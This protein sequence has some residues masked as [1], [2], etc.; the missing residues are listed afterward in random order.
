MKKVNELK[1][2]NI[3]IV[4]DMVIEGEKII[5]KMRIER[6]EKK[7]NERIDRR[8]EEKERENIVDLGK[9]I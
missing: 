3:G 6:R 5:D 2:K 1:N 4:E 8:K 7:D 9:E